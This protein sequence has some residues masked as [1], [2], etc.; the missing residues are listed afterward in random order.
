MPT[1]NTWPAAA[2]RDLPATIATLSERLAKLTAD[3]ATL[4]A[5]AGDPLTIRNRTA[6]PEDAAELLTHALDSLPGM[7]TPA[8]PLCLWV[9]TGA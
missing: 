7:V 6:S 9:S 1:S 3:L 4:E 5:H 2:V 8:T